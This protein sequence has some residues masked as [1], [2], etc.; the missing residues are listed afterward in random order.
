MIGIFDSGIGGLSVLRELQREIP[1]GDFLYFGDTAGGPYENK[2]PELVATRMADGLSYLADSGAGLLVVADH[3]AAACLT[4]D[5][6]RRFSIP[7]LDI[8]SDGVVPGV[9]ARG[10]KALGI[11]GPAVVETAGAHVEA[12]RSALPETRIYSAAAPLLYPLIEAGWM[13]RPET[14]M[15]VKKYL[16]FFKLRQID[17]LVLGSNHY[18]IIAPVIQRKIG[19]RVAVVDA[20]P[21]LAREAEDVYFSHAKGKRGTAGTGICRVVVSDL[22][23]GTAKNAR[24]F[25][26]KNIRLEHV[27]EV[28][29]KAA[30]GP[31]T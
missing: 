28:L 14:V 3:S 24:M 27:G 10:P 23:N 22:T 1:G 16:H 26:G 25:Y 9:N 8:L 13:K 21:V 17:T 15:I 31:S 11:I 7:L 30:A 29:L 19:K 18:S 2:S 4:A 12:L 20:A 6:R 5:I